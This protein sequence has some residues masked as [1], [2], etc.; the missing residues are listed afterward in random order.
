MKSY[1][2]VIAGAGIIGLSIAWQIRRRSK[3][4]ILVLDKGASVGAGSTGASSAVCRTR[5]TSDDMLCLARDGIHA[6]RNWGEF[7][8]LSKSRAQLYADGVLWMTG[9][10]HSWADTESLRLKNHGVHSQV[11]DD[12]ELN[13]RYP[14]LNPCV[15]K[16]DLAT[17]EDHQCRGGGR[18]LLETE[19]GYVDP[20]AA[21]EDLLEACRNS[22]VEVI[23]NSR[24][25]Q[26]NSAGGRIQGVTLDNG[27]KVAA[28]LLIN[29]AGPW[30]GELFAAAG[31][32]PAWNLVPTRIQVLYIDR[33]AEVPGHIPVTADMGSGIYFRTQ[34]R[35]QQL[36][37]GS[38]LAEDETEAVANPDQFDLQ[39][40]EEFK[41]T[42]L[43]IL[44]HRLPDLPYRGKIRGYCGLYTINRDDVHPILG[45]TELEG[46]WV[47]NG[48]SGHGFKL[49]PAIGSI[50]AQ[51]LTGQSIDFDTAVPMDL[52]DIKRSPI[53]V[54]SKTVMA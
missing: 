17:G 22:G 33:P 46:F 37:V 18:H 48:F 4:S 26:I 27:A 5:Y 28:P 10:D 29:A 14:A 13:A 16:P 42:K 30:C 9:E 8:G 31:V 2:L 34:N 24:V 50:I 25:N 41:Q 36:V 19:G 35:G 54:D 7:T 53:A 11:L 1:D 23:F 15:L 39:A 44:H 20:V 6:Y 43:H 47:A 12:V 45:Q 3:L 32:K 49:A 51:A 21:A 40:D 52:L 38:V